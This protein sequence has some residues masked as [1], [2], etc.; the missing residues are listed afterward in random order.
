MKT[1]FLT[2]FILFHTNLFAQLIIKPNEAIKVAYPMATEYKRTPL[3]LS[4]T[5]AKTVQDLIQKKLTSKLFVYFIIKKEKDTIAYAGL[6]TAHV[7]SKTATYMVLITPQGHIRS[8]EVIAFNE[9]SEY[10]PKSRW[11][12]LFDDKGISDNLRLK[13]S[14]PN[15][16]GATLSARSASDTAK[17]MLAVWQVKFIQR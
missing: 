8:I 9:P 11:L 17:L 5:E 14:I 7:R 4:Q 1:L 6:Y 10:I 12:R 15:L 3:L 13:E 2:V 16:S